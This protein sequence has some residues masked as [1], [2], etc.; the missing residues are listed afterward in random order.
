MNNR[1]Q[2]MSNERDM[3]I[4]RSIEFKRRVFDEAIKKHQGVID[5]F[6][7]RIDA[8]SKERPAEEDEMDVD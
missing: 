6:R 7:A 2:G 1:R 8:V 4:I 5:D 3:D